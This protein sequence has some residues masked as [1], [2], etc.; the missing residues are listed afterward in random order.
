MLQKKQVLVD[1]WHCA[2]CMNFEAIDAEETCAKTNYE[3]GASPN[4][5]ILPEPGDGSQ[6]ADLHKRE[7]DATALKGSTNDQSEEGF[8]RN[9][10]SNELQEDDEGFPEG[11]LQAWLVVLG[12]FSGLCMFSAPCGD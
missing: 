9:R 3:I 7:K 10:P 11:G 6:T 12:S 2:L 4:A 8:G 5:G 1:Y